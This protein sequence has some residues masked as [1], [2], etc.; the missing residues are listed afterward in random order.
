MSRKRWPKTVLVTGV[1]V[2]A[3]G[4]V[5]V[6]ALG[7]GGDGDT[8]AATHSA[9]LPSATGE[10][11]R[12]DLAAS[13]LVAGELGYGDPVTV[14]GRLPGT[15]TWLPEPGST[16]GR[17]DTL[18]KVDNQPVTLMY[19]TV[20]MYRDLVPGTEGPDV[21]QLNDNL[22]ALG[23]DAPDGDGYTARTA[24]ALRE[25]QKKRGVKTTGE[26]KNGQAAF[27]SSGLIRVAA[28]EAA[29]GD[30]ANGRILRHTSR[31]KRVRAELD[32]GDQGLA[33]K[34]AFV[35]VILP[36]GTTVTGKVSTVRTV[37]PPKDDAAQQGGGGEKP[38]TE[39]EVEIE[40][41]DQ[42]KLKGLDAATV[43]VKFISA[44]A[45][46]AMSVPVTALVALPDDGGYAVQ[47]VE[48]GGRTRT[49]PVTLGL[50]AQG[51]VEITGKG[52]REGMRVGVPK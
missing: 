17:G 32:V 36:D 20:P 41:P 27:A 45:Q 13:K 12:S 24:A 29:V 38:Q 25:F 5:S 42:K 19:G 21:E 7:L 47:V 2:L 40:I 33:K 51:R 3:G 44:T 46:K 6:A 31:E 10:I 26:L 15:V 30:P 48:G 18:Y 22:R 1:V 52:L 34:G 23:Y 14:S 8:T 49:V 37:S 35:G 11:S 39:V 16:V 9:Q 43:D 50:F 28:L 4:G